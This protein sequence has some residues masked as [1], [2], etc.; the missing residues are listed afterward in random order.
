MSDFCPAQYLGNNEMN[1]ILSNFV[2][3]LIL[4]RSRL[5]LLPFVFHKILSEFWPLL[6]VRF[7]FLFN[8]F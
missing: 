5:G 2:I 6:D 7:L 3:A 8:I 4:T 1:R